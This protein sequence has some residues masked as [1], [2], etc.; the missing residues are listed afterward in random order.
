MDDKTLPPIGARTPRNM[1][2]WLLAWSRAHTL[3]TAVILGFLAGWLLPKLV[4][5]LWA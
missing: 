5:L 3:T 4:V 1:I 2:R